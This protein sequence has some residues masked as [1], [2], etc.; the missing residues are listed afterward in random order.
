MASLIVV[1]CQRPYLGKLDRADQIRV[2]EEVQDEAVIAQINGDG[3]VC[4]QGESAQNDT[5]PSIVKCLEGHKRKLNITTD[6][7][8]A[9]TE[10]IKGMKRRRFSCSFITV[11]GIYTDIYLKDVVTELSQL[12]PHAEITVPIKACC[13]YRKTKRAFEW[14]YDLSNVELRRPRQRYTQHSQSYSQQRRWAI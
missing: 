6:A 13:S 1:N 2:V 8:S 14:V 10:A 3:I 4:L 11:C 5:H 12:L 9:A 7:G